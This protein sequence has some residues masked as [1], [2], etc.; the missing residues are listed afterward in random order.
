MPFLKSLPENAHLSDLFSR[1]PAHVAPLMA[2][3]DGLLR[4]P[5]ELSVG[6][7]EMIASFVSGLNACAFCHASHKVYAELFGI[8][9]GLIEAMV[10]DLGTAPV[11]DNLRPLLA[12]VAKLNK[13]PSR[14]VAADAQAVYDAG[15]TEQAL[16]EAVQVAALFNMM[17]RIVEGTGVDF[18]Y[19][20]NPE[21]HPAL[22]S[23][24]EKH[25][26][27]YSNFGKR[28]EA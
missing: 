25:A 27:S 4:E 15:W 2:Y 19:A 5:G 1:F 3:T 16:Y 17:N 8:D 22:G 13:L 14:L 18:D 6:E 21:R 24:P 7:R 9:A 20:A 11:A 12:Y 28:F 10:A 23:T 26:H